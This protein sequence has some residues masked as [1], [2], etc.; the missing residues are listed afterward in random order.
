MAPVVFNKCGQQT[1]SH[2]VLPLLSRNMFTVWVILSC[3]FTLT[4]LVNKDGCLFLNWNG[5]SML[6]CA[7]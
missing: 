1:Y 5:F 3:L 7:C 2:I 4:Y 6:Q